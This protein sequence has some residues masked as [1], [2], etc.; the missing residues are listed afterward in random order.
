[1][2]LLL[3]LFRVVQWKEW[4]VSERLKNLP[5]FISQQA[6]VQDTSLPKWELSATPPISPNP[7]ESFLHFEFLPGFLADQSAQELGS[8]TDSQRSTDPL[9]EAIEPS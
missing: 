9:T 6:F 5:P 3:A 8:G 7:C 4:N 1:M 2:T